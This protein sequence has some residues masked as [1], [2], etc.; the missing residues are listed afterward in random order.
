M[1]PAEIPDLLEEAERFRVDLDVD[2]LGHTLSTTIAGISRMVAETVR[3]AEEPF[4]TYTFVDAATLERIHRLI[5]V[6]AIVP[7]DADL[8]PAQDLLWTT[9]QEHQQGLR[10]RADHGDAI[11]R[12][13]C[14]ELSAL[15]EALG[16]AASPLSPHGRSDTVAAVP[17]ARE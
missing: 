14:A 10:A 2:G 4:A 8:A 15:A 16:V 5:E 17:G 1:R 13:W 9:L 7:F 11:A 3:A 12:H 6:V